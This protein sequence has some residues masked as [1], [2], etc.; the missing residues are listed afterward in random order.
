LTLHEP[1]LVSLVSERKADC[2]DCS[3]NTLARSMV[4]RIAPPPARQPFS[5][6]E[7]APC[8]SA[9]TAGTDPPARSRA[10]E[11]VPYIHRRTDAPVQSEFP[12][13][14]PAP[15]VVHC[16]RR[17]AALVQ[18]CR[19]VGAPAPVPPHGPLHPVHPAALLSV[20]PR[21]GQPERCALN[22]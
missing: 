12:S 19:S 11:R 10:I 18:A 20:G 15:S 1:S 6:R 3:A 14:A 13:D 4:R 7:S 2:R 17:K 9:A 21:A 16:R 8:R 5:P 22:A